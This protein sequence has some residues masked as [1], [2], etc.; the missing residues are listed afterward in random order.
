VVSLLPGET[1]VADQLAENPGT[2]LVH[3]HV[4]DHMMEGMFANFAVLPKTAPAPPAPFFSAAAAKQSLRWTKADVEME[5]PD[6][7]DGTFRAVLQGDVSI[8]RGY[9]PQRNPPAITIGAQ[10]VNLK[11]TGPDTAAAEG[12]Q[13]KIGGANAQGVVLKED[14]GFA[15][16]LE[17]PVWREAFAGLAKTGQSGEISVTLEL[18]GGK[19]TAVLP[20]RIERDGGRLRARLP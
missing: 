19:H 18:A 17:G 16:T 12:A 11:V 7:P 4:A 3:C 6:K 14:A 1:K 9:F 2:W 15:L 20:L 5:S 8:F 13:W 10:T